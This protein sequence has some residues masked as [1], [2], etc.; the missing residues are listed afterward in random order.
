VFGDG[1][2]LSSWPDV[3]ISPDGRWLGI[4]V[5]QGWSKSDLYL[6][7]RQKGGAAIPIVKGRDAIFSLVRVLDDR[8]LVLSNE[9]AA[10]YQLFA[11]DPGKPAR[12]NWRLVIPEAEDPLDSVTV[13]DGKLVATYLHDATSRVVVFDEDGKHLREIVLP[14][15]G[16]VTAARGHTIGATST[17]RSPRSSR[18]RAFCATTS[19]RTRPACGG[20]WRRRSIPRVSWSN[21]FATGRRTGLPFPCSWCTERAGS[22]T[23][24]TRPCSMATAASTSA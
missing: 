23:A 2:P 4:E 8:I 21:R 11:V 22:A 5:S 18:R 6:L 24:R 3:Q 15:L 19:R 13:A 7:D 1:L 14:G 10:R 17:C 20:R 9:G 12:E 16:T